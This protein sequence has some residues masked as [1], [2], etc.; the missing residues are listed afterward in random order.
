MIKYI[1]IQLSGTEVSILLGA[2]LMYLGV[3][4]RRTEKPSITEDDYQ[5]I[6]TLGEMILQQRDL[7]H[8]TIVTIDLTKE[9]LLDCISILNACLAE[10]D[11]DGVDLE[12]HLH[13][14]SHAPID[15]LIA[16]LRRKTGT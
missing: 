11:D 15:A 10:C 16:K 1:L 9:M 5:R 2:Q 7:A 6:D 13:T 14:R 8:G 4:F 12:L 3:P